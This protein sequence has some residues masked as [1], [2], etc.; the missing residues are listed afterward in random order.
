MV[1]EHKIGQNRAIEIDYKVKYIGLG[2]IEYRINREV[3]NR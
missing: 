1:G 3:Q 2:R